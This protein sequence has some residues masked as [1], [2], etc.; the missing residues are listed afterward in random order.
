MLFFSSHKTTLCLSITACPSK[1]PPR[2]LQSPP[3]FTGHAV[4]AGAEENQQR[5]LGADE[6]F[7]G[8]RRRGKNQVGHGVWR[9]VD[10]PQAG[11]AQALP[12]CDGLQT[13]QPDGATHTQ[14][15]TH[16]HTHRQLETH[17]H[18]HTETHTKLETHINIDTHAHT[19]T[20]TQLETHTH[21]QRHTI[22]NTHII[23][24]THTYKY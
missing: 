16:T 12:T 9:R 1:S 3:T 10:P 19:Q 18:T 15:E 14:L 24:N 11:A 7:A 2:E 8:P 20:H 6:A 23:R 21:T 4:L 17:T 5:Q 22:R 13:L